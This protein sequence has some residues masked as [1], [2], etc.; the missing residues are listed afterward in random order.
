MVL[1]IYVGSCFDQCLGC[2]WVGTLC[3]I[4][5]GRL[6]CNVLIVDGSPSSDEHSYVSEVP[7]VHESGHAKFISDIHVCLVVYEKFD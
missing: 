5:K 1:R 2:I 4:I 7:S 6:S 3:G